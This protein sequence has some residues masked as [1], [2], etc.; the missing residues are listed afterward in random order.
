MV[1]K[2]VVVT[3]IHRG[4]FF[5]R[6]EQLDDENITLLEAQNCIFWDASVKGVFGLAV[7]GPNENCR[8]GPIVPTLHLRGITSISK[9]TDVA[10]AAW[11]AQPWKV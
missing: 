11:K 9:A 3:T 5:G 2:Y 8:I 7:T 10:V 1:S 4:V 6:L